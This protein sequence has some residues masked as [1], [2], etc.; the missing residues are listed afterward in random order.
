MPI[1]E[2]DMLFLKSLSENAGF[3]STKD[4][5]FLKKKLFDIKITMLLWTDNEQTKDALR[6]EIFHLYDN[7]SDN[8]IIRL[9]RIEALKTIRFLTFVTLSRFLLPYK[10]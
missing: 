1:A 3:I 2:K 10:G 5:E 4:P 8:E 9:Y 6:R 7:L